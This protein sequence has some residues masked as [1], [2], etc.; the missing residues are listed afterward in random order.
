MQ[1][2]FFLARVALVLM[3][4][5]FIHSARADIETKR[6]HIE[7][8]TPLLIELRNKD[9]N[10][11]PSAKDRSFLFIKDSNSGSILT[12]ELVESSENSNVFKGIFQVGLSLGK[13][14]LPEIYLP[15]DDVL[16]S[17]NPSLVGSRLIQSKQLKRAAHFLRR[18]LENPNQQILSVYQTSNDALDAYRRYLAA[19][20]RLAATQPNT[21]LQQK[22]DSNPEDGNALA[23]KL[24]AVELAKIRMEKEAE[25]QERLRKQ[26]QQEVEDELNRKR[27]AEQQLGEQEKA[28]RR[29]QA[30]Q[31]AKRALKAYEAEDYKKAQALFE[32]SLEL[33]PNQKVYLYQYGITLF[34]L[35]KFD[36]AIIRLQ[37]AEGPDV[38]EPEKNYFLGL[39]YMRT[40]DKSKAIEAFD[41]TAKSKEPTLGP[42]ASFYKGVIRYNFEEYPEAKADFQEVLDTSQDP[43]LDKQAD[44]YI[45]KI[46]MAMQFQ[47]QAKRKFF[48]NS[49][50]AYNYDSNVLQTDPTGVFGGDPLGFASSRSLVSAGLDYR[51][52]FNERYESQVKVSVLDMRSANA[53]VQAA[54][55]TILS[56]SV[57]FKYR[58]T[59]GGR[60]YQLGT[61]LSY[62]AIS[63]NGAAAINTAGLKFDGNLFSSETRLQSLQIQ[64]QTDQNQIPTAV[65]DFD[66]NAQRVS[67]LYASTHF[68]NSGKTKSW[69]WDLGAIVNNA[70][71]RQLRNQR[72]SAGVGYSSPFY[73]QTSANIKASVFSLN[74]QDHLQDRSDFNASLAATLSRPLSSWISALAVLNLMANQST[75]STTQFEKSSLI[76]GVTMNP[77][78]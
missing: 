61:S 51:F 21:S 55:P 64:F 13:P 66:A 38:S 77:S 17:K 49:L 45:E 65:G 25:E 70:V 6:A 4:L 36:E 24:S 43:E 40:K 34:R 22:F 9:W 12:V 59:W 19:K 71:G 27:L 54:D 47:E 41:K 1:I 33:D 5:V 10:Q 37:L 39:S 23:Q 53:Q 58:G 16:K 74:F 20:Q 44:E 63:L 60:G 78:F 72:L 67:L 18:S 69:N 57:P 30:E 11:N 42:A 56:V 48:V 52:L 35:E 8:T 2:D 31:F 7:S 50:L 26:R 28:K 29:A 75:V 46:A 68:L 76:L 14:V 32:K 73:F 62:D 15:T 3:S